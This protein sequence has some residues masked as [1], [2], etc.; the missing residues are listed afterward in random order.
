MARGVRRLG[1]AGSLIAGAIIVLL[2]A[3][4]LTAQSASDYGTLVDQYASANAGE[5]IAALARFSPS[6]IATLSGTAAR[7][8]STARQ[9]AAIMLHTDAA[10]TLLM[11]DR[12]S[13]A[14]VQTAAARRILT[15]MRSRAG[16]DTRMRAFE[17]R[18]FAG[19][20]SMYTAVG[21][22]DDASIL[23]RDG[24]GLHPREP[25]LF[26]A[27]GAIYEMNAALSPADSRVG[28]Q[29]ARNSRLFDSAARDFLRAI[30]YDETLAVA[31][32]HLGWVRFT[33]GDDRGLASLEAALAHADD[34]RVRYLAHLFCGRFAERQNRIED[35]R[36]EYEAAMAV[37]SAY[38]SAYVALSRIEETL[39]HSARARDLA[40][41]YSSLR[42]KQED[43]WWD[44]HLGG[45]DAIT[46]EWLRREARTP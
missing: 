31:H 1:L 39:G 5:S 20:A 15:A 40:R 34:D 10:Y 43:P 38:Q 9:R 23:I 7:D 6:A 12:T 3:R 17:A 13:A 41:A 11:L 37:G 36:R 29:L 18:W 21:R 24:F 14:S 27:R 26:V 4:S 45:F 28:N 42:D 22:L 16:S 19:V 25:R 44:Y 8:M 33:T 30:A 35:A 32:L 2:A 46:F